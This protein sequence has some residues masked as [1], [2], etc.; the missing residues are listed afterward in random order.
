MNFFP[1][2]K[3]SDCSEAT[4]L[5]PDVKIEI[6][7]RCTSQEYVAPS[8]LAEVSRM[9]TEMCRG[10]L[11]SISAKRRVAAMRIA[12]EKI[13]RNRNDHAQRQIERFQRPVRCR[14]SF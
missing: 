3:H 8:T 11:P 5:L 2:I 6:T 13:L 1:T 14:M 10:K 7:F 4:V 9:S 12:A